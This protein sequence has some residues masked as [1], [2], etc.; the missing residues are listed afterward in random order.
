MEYDRKS[1]PDEKIRNS[2]Y[3]FIDNL[4]ITIISEAKTH[5]KSANFREIKIHGSDGL[6]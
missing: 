1:D 2:Y 6:V 3:V 4:K 5:K